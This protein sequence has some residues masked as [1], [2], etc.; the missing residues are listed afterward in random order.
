MYY[1]Y[2]VINV[3]V[4][5]AVKQANG[6]HCSKDSHWPKRNSAVSSGN[7]RSCFSGICALSFYSLMPNVV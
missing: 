3:L 2:A 6:S 5:D 7:N 1:L 4:V